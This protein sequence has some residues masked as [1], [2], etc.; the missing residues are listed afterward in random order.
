MIIKLL[1]LNINADNYWDKLIPY[2]TSHDFDIIQLQELS[3]KDTVIGNI[4]SQRDTF[5]ELQTILQDKYYGE[6]SISQRYT[7]S[8]D[9]YMGSGTFY[10]KSF[11]LVK[12]KEIILSLTH[13]YFPSDKTSYEEVGR[14]LLHLIFAIK[15]K[16]ISFLNTHFAW[17][18]NNIEKPHQTKQGEVLLNYL[19]TVK[20]PF[21][22][23]GDFNLTPKQPLMQKISKLVRNLTEEH[24]LTNTLDPENHRAKH[25]F[26]KGLAV[27][28]IFT[29]NDL[30]V[31][32]FAVIN[33]GLSDH[34]GLTAEIEI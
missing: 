28:Y 2:L 26:P 24:H 27:D 15:G 3:G 33:E 13:E 1:Q 7:S 21:V 34:F 20:E 11:S 18:P 6:L 23:T 8:L 10:K 30:K 16:H 29:S 19:Q 22:L 31:K 25:L 32:N 12:K 14:T 17:G 4:N 5:A 9:S